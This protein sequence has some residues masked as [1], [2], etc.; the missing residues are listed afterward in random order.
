LL[1]YLLPSIKIKPVTPTKNHKN[2]GAKTILERA[3]GKK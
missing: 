1:E 3:P 2:V